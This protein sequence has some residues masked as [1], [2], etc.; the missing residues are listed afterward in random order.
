MVSDTCPGE[1]I[2]IVIDPLMFECE[3]VG[4]QTV[5]VTVSDGTNESVC[6]TT[7]TVVDDS[8]PMCVAKDITV[9]LNANGEATITADQVDDGSSAGCDVMTLSVTPT[10][11][12]C[13]DV[14]QNNP[15]TLT[16]TGSNGEMAF[17]NALV[18]VLDD[19][20]PTIDCID[21]ITFFLDNMGELDITAGDLLLSA[22]DNCDIITQEASPNDF[23]CGDVGGDASVVTVTVTDEN[24]NSSECTSNVTV[25]DNLDPICTITDITIGPLDE[26]NLSRSVLYVFR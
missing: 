16:V 9:T 26:F 1:M 10:M 13:D 7:V 5:T 8:T 20:L 12:E 24:G 4:M 6:M 19:E 15:V 11:F 25:E 2:T 18:T 21:D 14:D 23:D 22:S 3:D 17:C